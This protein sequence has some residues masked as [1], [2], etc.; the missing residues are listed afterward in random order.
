M[1]KM[2]TEKGWLADLSQVRQ[3]MRAQSPSL[4]PPGENSSQPNVS[5]RAGDHIEFD[6]GNKPY[7][8]VRDA[9]G[10]VVGVTRDGGDVSWV[11]IG[12]SVLAGL[13]VIGGVVFVIRMRMRQAGL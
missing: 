11:V 4:S 6:K 3:L 2:S 7:D 5:V 9:S 8:L 1:M 10:K 12:L 13:V